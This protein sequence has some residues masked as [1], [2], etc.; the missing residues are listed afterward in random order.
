MGFG[1]SISGAPNLSPSARDA[2][3]DQIAVL[4][5]RPQ[6]RA[7][8]DHRC[9]PRISLR[10]T[11]PPARASSIE[12]RCVDLMPEGEADLKLPSLAIR[13]SRVAWLERS[14]PPLQL[15]GLGLPRIS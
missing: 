1:K 14:V 12:R 11:D 15:D 2:V 4:M 5:I 13:A 3:R 8:P 7:E 9:V 6:T 10:C